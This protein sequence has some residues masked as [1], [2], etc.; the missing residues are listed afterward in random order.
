MDNRFSIRVRLIIIQRN[1]I[2][3]SYAGKE[4]FYFFP[5]GKVE[6]KETLEEAAIREIKE[7]CNARFTFIKPLYIRDFFGEPNLHNLEIYI[8]GKIDKLQKVKDKEHPDHQQVWKKL[9]ELPGID[10]RPKQLVPILIRDY[11]SGFFP[12]VQYLGKIE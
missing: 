5:G 7:E 2:L 1:R 12:P 8:L 3:L 4:N 9:E 10:I 6:F 11:N